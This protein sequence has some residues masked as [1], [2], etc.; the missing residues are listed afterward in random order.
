M[1]S[2]PILIMDF[3][4]YNW[5]KVL[6][7][8]IAA[9]SQT[10]IPPEMTATGDQ[11]YCAQSRLTI[12]TDFMITD[13]DN[14]SI[15]AVYIQISTGY[16]VGEDLLELTGNHPEISTNWN[17]T[18]GKL[19]LKG[20][21]DQQML[22][23]DVVDA[24]K[25]IVF[26]NSSTAPSGERY[27]SFTIGD[28]NY[29][30]STGHYYEY[31]AD[32]G[33]TWTTARTAAASRTYY[34]LQGYLATITSPEEAQLSGEQAAGAGWIGGSDAETEGIWKWVTGPESGTIFWNGGPD[35]SSPNYAFWNTGEP[36]NLNDEDYAHVT[37]PT[38]GITGSWNDLPNGGTSGDF[39]PKGYVV[40]Y[41]GSPDDPELNLSA[42][43][44]IYIP[45]ITDTSPGIRC[46]V[47]QVTLSAV[48]STGTVHWF[49]AP[50]DGNLLGEET[51]F[52]TPVISETTTYYAEAPVQGCT[53]A[54]RTA[55]T[56]T[57][58]PLPEVENNVTFL[59]CDEDGNPDGF[60][61]F[62]LDEIIPV[63]TSNDNTLVVSY[64]TSY[65]EAENNQ[66]IITDLIINNSVTD[67]LYARV[68]NSYGCYRIVTIQL[69][70]S[71]THFPVDY[72][73]ELTTCDDDATS[74]GLH[75]FDLSEATAE[76]ISQFPSGQNLSVHYYHTLS[77]ATLEKNE[78][79]P[80]DNYINEVPYSEILYVRVESQENGN[81]YGIGPHLKLIVY[82]RPDF[83]VPQDAFLCLNLPPITIEIL[84]AEDD[85]TYTWTD[86]NGNVI[87]NENT[88]EIS[89]GGEISV[90]ATSVFGCESFPKTINIHTS[91]IADFGEDDIAIVDDSENNTITILTENNNLGIGDYQ[92]SLDLVDGMYQEEPFFEHVSPGVH[93]IFVK[94]INGCGI[95]H[96][97]VLVMGFPRFFTP[98]NDGYNDIWQLKGVEISDFS[99][100]VVYIYDRFGKVL[101]KIDAITGGW[102]GK[103]NGNDMPE[104]DYWFTAELTDLEGNIRYRKGHFSLI[105]R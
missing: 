74:D 36:N 68:E 91:E 53:N 37:A 69:N 18:E 104:S 16:V 61:D 54:Y 57:I 44:R 92:F 65:A 82:P 60:T 2:N 55:V 21:N 98:N 39:F 56:A 93:T 88:A 80:Q 99:S 43:T 23:T 76:L 9:Y 63:L 85:Y 17:V 96:Q 28:A 70:A 20:V 72:E 52:T 51:N 48:S 22:Y 41:G 35:G 24:V 40:E 78:I 81:C 86:A 4:K 3:W 84:S 6:F 30:P 89:T 10:D 11:P 97:E 27:F 66:N 71:T 7:F 31:V 42:S 101:A 32:Y 73:Y 25:D 95:A 47:G 1:S 46:G 59:N 87:S 26:Y 62:N 64:F 94:D 50:Q 49:D 67:T 79:I 103:Y 19:E 77:D 90:V 38:V 5:I 83:E 102:N 75:V 45:E 15:E 29:L 33:I 8:S 34:G 100:V 13:P 12:V 14:T 58:N 105:R